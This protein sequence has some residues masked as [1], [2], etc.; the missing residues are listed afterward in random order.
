MRDPA[1]D[2][3]DPG[4]PVSRRAFLGWSGRMAAGAAVAG[5][6]LATAPALLAA[7]GS[8][9]SKTTTPTSTSAGA[10]PTG[11]ATTPVALQFV[12]L[13]NVQF[14]GSF[15]ADTR[16]YYAANGLKVDLL[17]GGPNLV[18][19]PVVV[20]GKA[21]V[22]I[23][24]T[25]EAVQAIINGAPIKIIG[26]GYQK[27]PFC[28]VS[29]ASDPIVNPQGLIGRKVGV[30]ASNV[31]IWQSFLKANH[32]DES[33]ITVVT[34]QFDPTPL[35]SKE[36]DG[37]VGFYTNEPILLNTKGVPTHAYLLNDYGYPLL[38]ELYIVR[39]ADLNDATKRKQIVGLMT[40]ESKG[41]QDALN[42]AQT[43]ATLATN[44]YGKDLHLDLNQQVLESKAQN[45]LVADADTAAHGLF[46]MT[47]EKV[48][49]TINS[50]AIG[51][52]V[53]TASIFTN[54]ILADV[55]RNGIKP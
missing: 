12:Y 29:R 3:A 34:V 47:P 46:W 5:T 16:G 52:V 1:G 11:S 10:A 54:E 41:W 51:G 50:L 43:A 49:A 55:Y 33:K 23:S 32:I 31:P 45:D 14:A 19:E 13:K 9:S 22:A 53:A 2:Q 20:S 37:L 8:S 15:F 6:A 4:L 21:L 27:N 18:V 17:S 28:I 38:E 44:T 25:N 40:A 7:C 48:T 36:I 39:T 42:D 26:A 35:A 30:S 24:H